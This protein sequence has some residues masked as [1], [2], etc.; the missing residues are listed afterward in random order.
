ML[1]V[2]MIFLYLSSLMLGWIFRR[3]QS[4][5]LWLLILALSCSIVS[6]VIIL[7]RYEPRKIV[8][9]TQEPKVETISSKNLI[10]FRLWSGVAFCAGVIGFATVYSV[11]KLRRIHV[12]M[13][14][15]CAVFLFYV[16]ATYD[17]DFLIHFNKYRSGA[18]KSV[19]GLAVGGST[20]SAIMVGTLVYATCRILWMAWASQIRQNK[21]RSLFVGVG[22]AVLCSFFLSLFCFGS[23]SIFNTGK[24]FYPLGEKYTILDSKFLSAI[25]FGAAV[26]V[27]A[28]HLSM[29]RYGFWS[30]WRI[31]SRDLDRRIAFSNQAVRIALHSYKNRFL[32]VQMAMDITSAQLAPLSEARVTQAMLQ[33]NWVKDTCREALAALDVLQRQAQG[34]EP[35]P[36]WVELGDVWRVVRMKWG[37]NL[38]I[39]VLLERGLD[40]QLWIWGDRK[41]LIPVFE[42]LFQNAL[43]ALAEMDEAERK[44]SITVTLGREHEWGYFRI[45]DNGPGISPR[46]MK[47]I[48]Q[49]FYSTKP[50]KSNWGLGLTYCHRVIKLHRG[51]INLKSKLGEG[52][53]FEVVLRCR[54]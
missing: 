12:W 18:E 10:R 45:Q 28:F 2:S 47:R 39:V 14:G 44:A 29:L 36:Y 8:A 37:S 43:D 52:T 17:P 23:N 3:A 19:F 31:S 34:L 33:I 35:E 50:S 25:P 7:D 6:L 26:F 15:G 16:I 40:E 11:T 49:P 9:A 53:T 4:V 51:Y 21:M 54:R 27:L 30:S 20:H 46:N 13:L 1:F 24:V 42:N 38:G 5:W 41:L 48:F 22:I 32:G